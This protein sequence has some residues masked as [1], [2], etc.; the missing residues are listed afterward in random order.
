MGL[1]D[2]MRPDGEAAGAGAAEGL[3]I[4]VRRPGLLG[5]RPH[6]TVVSKLAYPGPAWG[7]WVTC[8][9]GSGLAGRQGAATG[10]PQLGLACWLQHPAAGKPPSGLLI[11]LRQKFLL[12]SKQNLSIE[13]SSSCHF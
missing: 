3:K 7:N 11:A 1:G 2:R 10:S 13:E 8:R 12:Y 6:G 9:A 4:A 5:R